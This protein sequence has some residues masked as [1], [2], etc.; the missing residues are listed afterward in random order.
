MGTDPKATP[1]REPVLPRNRAA[2]L[3]DR[4]P[5][6]I[7]EVTGPS[8]RVSY[9]NAAFCRLLGKTPAELVGKLFAEIVPGGDECLPTLDRVY[10]TGEAVTLERQTDADRNASH[11]LFAMWPTLDVNERAVGVIIQMTRASDFRQN[12][13]AINEALLI[14]SLRQ[15]ELTAEAVKLNA[16]LENEIIERRLAEA[17]LVAANHRL[18]EQAAELE[19]LVAERTAKLRETVRELE[20]FSYSIAHEMRAPLQGMQGFARLLADEHS[21]QLDATARGYLDRITSSA[22]RMDGLIQ[23]VLNYTRL[24]H[25]DALLS[26][27]DLDRLVREIIAVYPDW[28]PPGVEI[29]IAQPLPWVLGHEGFLTQCIS[30]LLSN[31]VKFVA[32]GVT[33]HVRIWAEN[34]PTSP[35]QPSWPA[36]NGK[37][38]E[39]WNADGPVVRLCVGNNGIGIAVKDRERVFRMF[40]R[41]NPAA[42]FEGTGIGLTIVR[43]AAERM[44]GRAG[45]DALPAGGSTF[46]IE[47]KKAPEPASTTP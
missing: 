18:A 15:H 23:D 37:V 9:V 45:F 43:T 34:R 27:T 38:A 40:D 33:P 47:L 41:I 10:E 6:P 25:E 32:P 8:H 16:Q 17:A 22:S 36:A 11:W 12:A 7:I 30:N 20:G 5:L 39:G 35:S 21:G 26:P 19:R 29:E 4:A 1:A 28:K 44:G 42:D 3:I 31:A 13:A 14:S 2:P 46:W 24:L